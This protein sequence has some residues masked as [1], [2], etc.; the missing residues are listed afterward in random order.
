MTQIYH[1]SMSASSRYVRLML[2][3]YGQGGEFIEEKPWARRPDFLKLN[4][5]GTLPVMIEG[6]DQPICGAII[7]GEYLD[8]TAGAMM[9]E[10]RLMPENM[11][12]RAEVRRLVEWFIV[13]FDTEVLQYLVNERVYKQLMNREE[14]GGSP[15]STVIRAGRINLKSH[16]R[17]LAWLAG[18]R[19]WLSGNRMTQADL[20]A[21]AGLSVLDYLGEISWESEPTVRDW[22]A[23]IKS[24]PS[25]RP[26]LADKV[27]GLPPAS[28]YI[29]LDF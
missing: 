27:A 17:Y 18:S 10:K 6:E 2:G 22:Y 20:A 21:A 26:L 14:G 23:R 24:R 8:E 11:K 28:H 5:A 29:D 13:K 12:E 9:R 3:E 19:N 25:F 4:P 7:I 1:H 15:D 16:L